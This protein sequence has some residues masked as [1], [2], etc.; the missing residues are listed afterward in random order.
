GTTVLASPWVPH[1]D[2]RFFEEPLAFRPGR[3]AGDLARRLPRYAYFPFGGGPR[4]CIGSG[5]ALMEAALIVAT[6]VPRFRFTLAPGHPVAP[7]G[8]VTLR[9]EQGIKALLHRRGAAPAGA[10]G[11]GA[12]KNAAPRGRPPPH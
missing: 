6:V 9:P 10:R 1:R 7:R 8:Y 5:F 4:V 3:W 11:G 2:G 12:G